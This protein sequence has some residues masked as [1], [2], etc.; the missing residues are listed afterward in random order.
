LEELST[1]DHASRAIK[2]LNDSL[3]TLGM[4]TPGE[5][6]TS[7]IEHMDKSTFIRFVFTNPVTHDQ[8]VVKL[9]EKHMWFSTEEK[10]EAEIDKL[11]NKTNSL[12]ESGGK[13]TW[14]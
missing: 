5:R 10:A 8:A 4:N 13:L 9:M 11:L 3:Q 1:K 14:V 6:N 7:M 2:M 12:I